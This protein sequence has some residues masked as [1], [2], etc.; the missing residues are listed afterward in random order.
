[1]RS[2]DP[3]RRQ[4]TYPDRL[5]DCEEALEPVFIEMMEL[6]FA[7]GWGPDETRKALFR[8][9]AAHRRAQTETAT[10]EAELAVLRARQ[11]AARS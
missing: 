3:P 7:S 4:E 11:R 1:M 6:A 2:I 9:L 8:L 10:L 5:I